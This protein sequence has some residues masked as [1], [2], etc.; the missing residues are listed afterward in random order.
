MPKLARLAVVVLALALARTGGAQDS[1]GDSRA[2]TTP[3]APSGIDQAVVARYWQ[4]GRLRPAFTSQLEVGYA[5]IKPRFGMVYGR[6][7]WHW[8]GLDAYPLVSTSG[9]G[10]YVG[11]S[12]AWP[13]IAVRAG[14]RYQYPFKRSLL[15]PRASYSRRDLALLEG[16]RAEYRAWEAELTLTLPAWAGSV[17]AVLTGYRIDV[18]EPDLFLYEESLR[19]VVEPPYLWR[20]RLGYLFAFGPAGAIRFGPALELIGMPT[21]EEHVLRAGVVGSVSINAYLEAQASFIPVLISPDNLGLEGGDF[22]QL[23]VRF[24]WATDSTPDPD[25]VREYRRTSR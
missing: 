15:E 7:Y 1:L 14:S 24:R 20:A 9:L 23:G 10:Y 18:S 13:G 6:P 3:A 11:L 17:F 19:V 8:F 5:Y 16:P 2:T 25:R 22:G 21:R 4:L 12:G